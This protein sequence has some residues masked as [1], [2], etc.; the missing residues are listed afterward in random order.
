MFDSNLI[1]IFKDWNKDTLKYQKDNIPK[2]YEKVSLKLF[3][4]FKVILHYEKVSL[5]LLAAYMNITSAWIILYA[6]CNTT[7]DAANVLIRKK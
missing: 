5:K 7:S 1:Y 6:K 3:C 2:H 4:K